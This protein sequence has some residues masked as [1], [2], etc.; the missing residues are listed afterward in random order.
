M[1]KAKTVAPPPDNYLG[2]T[3]Q[4][5]VEEAD[6]CVYHARLAIRQSRDGAARGLFNTAIALYERVL[7][8]DANH[9]TAIRRLRDLQEE[10]NDVGAIMSQA[11]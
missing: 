5:C 6:L 1:P 3:V 2:L 10:R 11:S 9:A 8:I 7:Q 4:D